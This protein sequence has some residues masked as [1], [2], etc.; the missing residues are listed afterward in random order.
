MCEPL[1][2]RSTLLDLAEQYRDLSYL[3]EFV[4]LSYAPKLL[5]LGLFPDAKEITESMG[6]FN[7]V[8]RNCPFI[9]EDNDLVISVGDGS[10]PRTASLFSE[11]TN[12]Q[13]LSIDPALKDISKYQNALNLS[14]ISDTIEN[15]YIEQYIDLYNSKRVIIVAVHSH[16]Y[17]RKPEKGAKVSSILDVTISKLGKRIKEV[18]VAALPCCHPLYVTGNNFIKEYKDY[19]IHSE[20]NL[21]R[22][23]DIKREENCNS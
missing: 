2:M 9:F 19:S 21:I 3:D 1:D 23:W 22:L 17:V 16:N 11:L 8:R 7:A 13:V 12:M 18:F 15:A 5:S 4:R 10:T 6:I 20:H 14:C